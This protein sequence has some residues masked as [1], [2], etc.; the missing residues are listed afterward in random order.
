MS[1]A[2]PEMLK[3]TVIGVLH[4]TIRDWDLELE[5]EIGSETKLIEEL[6]FESID[7]VQFFVALEQALERKD[8]HFEKLLIKEG[9]YVDDVSVNEI[10]DFVALE[11]QAG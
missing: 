9:A 6:A 4:E 11:L 7:I 3:S 8:L 10:V 5:E 2:S 1:K